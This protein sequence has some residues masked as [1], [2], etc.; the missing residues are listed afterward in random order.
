MALEH[1]LEND[2]F[3]VE[4]MHIGAEQEMV[5]IDQKTHKP[6][7]VAMEAMDL[8]KDMEWLETE[9]ASF[10]L[11]ICLTPQP[12]K[13][14]CLSAMHKEIASRLGIISEN[15]NTL[16]TDLLLTGILPTLAKHHLVME[17]LTPKKRYYALMQAMNKQL[18]GSSFELRLEG[19][20]E[21]RLKHDSPML[22][23]SN[24]SFQVH[25]QVEPDN[26][27]KMYNIA[28]AITGP[29][30]AIA[31]N[32]P[33]V[34]G[35]RLWHES[36]IAMFQ[37]SIDTRTSHQHLR[38]R[39]PR[40]S[41][42]RDWL[43]KSI[44]EI[45]KED[46]SRFRVLLSSDVAEESLELIKNKK[47]PKL[48]ALQVHNSTVYRW[49]R[50]CYG[51]SPNGKPHLRIENRVLPSGP[52]VIDEMANATLWLGLMIGLENQVDDIRDFLS[53]EDVLDN[54]E[55]AAKFG[56]DTE[57][58]WFNDEKVSACRLVKEKLVPI[59]REGL[60]SKKVKKEDIDKYLGVIEARADKHM[61]GAR[62]LLR[63]YT[64]LKRE[65][66]QDE[67]LSI[68]THSI[69]ETQKKGIPV[70]E[71]EAP[72]MNVNLYQPTDLK[73][74]DFMQ[75]DIQTVQKDDIIDLVAEMMDWQK[76][77]YT[78]VEDMK[79][80]LVGLV[81]DRLIIRHFVEDKKNPN[82]EF[83]TVDDIMIKNPVTIDSEKSILEAMNLMREENVGCLPVTQG[84]ELIG[85]ITERDFLG[86]TGRLFEKFIKTT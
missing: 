83:S 48:R 39:S 47:T 63:S 41:F 5:I 56:I 81:T 76:V 70:H 32:S 14:D 80:N 12:F 67:A 43:D 54:F 16:N 72:D 45:Y 17:N 57:F 33:L 68:L 34:F 82:N 4:Q 28:Q 13:G 46:I 11:E 20:D 31:A 44:L 78:A 38:E 77:K 27:V 64:Q 71:W 85:M 2:W 9:L 37:Q 24:T 8:M 10:N 84:E 79:G 21:L 66:T 26:F 50:P 86:I 52:T 19:I 30:M 53:F 6:A 29:V 65:R 25:L 73:I 62:W 35:K 22:E 55:K 75:T 51:I 7:L 42:G 59:A 18:I 36:R 60:M 40:V 3:D 1:M 58:N 15:L 61:N 74:S 69:M 23:A 49:N